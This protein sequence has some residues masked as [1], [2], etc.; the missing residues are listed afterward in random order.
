MKG[1]KYYL[2]FYR[3]FKDVRLVFAPPTCFGA[4]G[5]DTDNWTWPQHKGDF[6]MYRVYGNKDGN[7]AE[8]SSSNVPITPKYVLQISNKGVK[9]GD[10]AMIMGYPYTTSR[11]TP[12]WGVS[13]K[14]ERTTPAMIKVRTKKLD[15]LNEAMSSEDV[16]KRQ[17]FTSA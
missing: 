3:I 13:E 4:F 2:Y 17:S 15:I 16:Y 1:D 10:Y 14:I 6:T 8:Y 9:E 7:P 12:S 11:Y 5:K